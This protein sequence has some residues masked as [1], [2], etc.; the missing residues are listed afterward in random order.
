MSHILLIDDDIQVLD[1]ISEM[2][3]LEGHTNSE[4]GDIIQLK[5][6]S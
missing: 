2:L 3:K 1:V 5:L 4:I 6:G